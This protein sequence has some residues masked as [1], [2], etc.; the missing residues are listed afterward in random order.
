M[1]RSPMYRQPSNPRAEGP[2]YKSASNYLPMQNFEKISR[3]T[4]SVVVTPVSASSPRSAS[5]KSSITISWGIP[6]STA[7]RAESS[8]RSACST[9]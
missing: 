9:A 1:G 2:L 4:S 3:N 8:P 6:T 5:Y 7:A